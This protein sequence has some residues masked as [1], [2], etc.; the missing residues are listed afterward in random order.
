M[1]VIKKIF[2]WMMLFRIWISLSWMC[3]MISWT[4]QPNGSFICS[5]NRRIV[6]MGVIWKHFEHWWAWA[7]SPF[8]AVDSTR[9]NIHPNGVQGVRSAP[10]SLVF[11]IFEIMIIMVWHVNLNFVSYYI[12]FIWIAIFYLVIHLRR[13]TAI[14]GVEEEDFFTCSHWSFHWFTISSSINSLLYLY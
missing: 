4:V 2:D 8:I 11:L 14:I 9:L 3:A 5:W 6:D 13:N 10:R 12:S 7:P 1:N